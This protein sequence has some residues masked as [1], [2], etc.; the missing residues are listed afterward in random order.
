M[1]F[2]TKIDNVC[3]I[4]WL[5]LSIPCLCLRIHF[6]RQYFYGQK[7]GWKQEKP[8][9]EYNVGTTSGDWYSGELNEKGI[10]VSTMRDGTPKGMPF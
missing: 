1:S 10:P 2:V 3:S 5:H 7:D 4:F 9:H 8:H 6:Q